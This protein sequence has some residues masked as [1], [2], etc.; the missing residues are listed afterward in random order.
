MEIKNAYSAYYGI[1]SSFWEDV[2]RVPMK[3]RTRG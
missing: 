1:P 3:N 2:E